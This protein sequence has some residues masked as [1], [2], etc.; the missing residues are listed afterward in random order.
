[1]TAAGTDPAGFEQYRKQVPGTVEKYGLTWDRCVW[2]LATGGAVQLQP[3][4]TK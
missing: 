2:P 3:A 1:V 4:S